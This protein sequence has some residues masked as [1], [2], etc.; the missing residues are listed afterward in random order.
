[1]TALAILV[2]IAIVAPVLGFLFALAV[3]VR[4]I[5][6]AVLRQVEPTAEQLVDASDLWLA[7]MCRRALSH[8]EEFAE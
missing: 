6:W 5:L 2:A 7:E 3:Y 8:G 4:L 1:M